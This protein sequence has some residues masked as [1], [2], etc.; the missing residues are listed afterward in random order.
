MALCNGLS[1][2][3]AT[4]YSFAAEPIVIGKDEYFCLGDNREV[5]KDSRFDLGL[6]KRK[7]IIGKVEIRI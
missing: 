6:V 4:E 2:S 5:S 3:E 7:D 1:G